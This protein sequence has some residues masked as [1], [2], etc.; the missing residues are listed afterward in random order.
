MANPRTKA[1]LEARIQER[2]AYCV[3]FELSDPRSAFITITKAELSDDLS[4]AKIFYS[5]YGTEGDKSRVRHMLEDAKGFVRTKIASVL[6]VRRAPRVTWVYDDS[7][8]YQARMDEAIRDALLRDRDVNPDAHSD[9]TIEV[10]EPAEEEVLDREY[11]DFLRAR[12]EEGEGDP[13][14]PPPPRRD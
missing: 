10:P 3:E 7:I 14:P 1:R 4:V 8:E 6:R 11:L 2:A 9:L 12:E 13:E 5:V